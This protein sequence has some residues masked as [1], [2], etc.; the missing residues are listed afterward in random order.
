M[1]KPHRSSP[2]LNG[3]ISGGGVTA[4]PCVDQH[5][6]SFGKQELGCCLHEDVLTILHEQRAFIDRWF[7]ALLREMQSKGHVPAEACIFQ[8]EVVKSSQ[9]VPLPETA[10]PKETL[11]SATSE[12]DSCARQT[13]G[14]HRN[15]L[16]EQH[17]QQKEQEEHEEQEE[18]QERLERRVHWKQQ[19]PKQASTTEEVLSSQKQ[20]D[21][22]LSSKGTFSNKATNPRKS[23]STSEAAKEVAR[24]IQAFDAICG[25]KRK[26]SWDH[27]DQVYDF[28]KVPTTSITTT[29]TTKDYRV[30]KVEMQRAIAAHKRSTRMLTRL[31]MV[32]NLLILLNTIFVG[33]QVDSHVNA[34][35][36][37]G[38]TPRWMRGLDM[39]IMICFGIELCT[40]FLLQ[41]HRFFTGRQKCWNLFDMFLFLCHAADF[42]LA[43][44]NISVVRSIR[45]LKAVRSVR[46][47]KSLRFVRDLRLMLASIMCSASSIFW[48]FVLLSFLLYVFAVFIMQGMLYFFD[49]SRVAPSQALLDHY[50]T[51]A[52]TMLSLFMAISGGMDW[53]DLTKP[54]T[55]LSPLYIFVFIFYVLFVLFGIMNILTAIFC[56]S[57]NRIAQIDRDLVIQEQMNNEESTINELRRVLNEFDEDNSS[58]IDAEEFELLL[59]DSRTIEHLK[60]L[61]LDLTEAKGLFTLLDFTGSGNVAIDEFVNTLMR[62]QG[63][64]KGVDLATIIYENKRMMARISQLMRYVHCKFDLLTAHFGIADKEDYSEGL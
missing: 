25:L 15:Q 8:A 22:V 32:S 43:F 11:L 37:K 26:G 33:L 31:D 34:A 57:A 50:G 3:C 4:A 18:K 36:K 46:L 44:A 10:E 24:D 21:R 7:L 14:E 62:L 48:A 20:S 27:E 13:R 38:A 64:A 12:H 40:R 59:S 49:Q 6:C 45:V 58:T 30:S 35:F 61:G 28:L 9:H 47:I 52:A 51:L 60:T 16:Q 39:F 2:G 56:E 5:A 53:S 63:N 23:S 42:L 17:K 1:E 54:L 29:T 55:Q 41:K 19:G